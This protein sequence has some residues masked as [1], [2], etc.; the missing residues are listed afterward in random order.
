MVDKSWCHVVWW[1]ICF[2]HKE[3]NSQDIYIINAHHK[4][5]ITD[6]HR[7][8]RP[9]P[10]RIGELST[11]WSWM[12][13]I[14][15]SF[16]CWALSTSMSTPTLILQ[17][18][19]FSPSLTAKTPNPPSDSITWLYLKPPIKQSS[20]LRLDSVLFNNKGTIGIVSNVRDY[21]WMCS[22]LSQW[23]HDWGRKNG[24]RIL[25]EPDYVSVCISLQVALMCIVYI[26]IHIL[27][28]PLN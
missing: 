9:D 25:I 20:A 2:V 22:Y 13:R 19:P 26:Y 10:H 7:K 4:V 28:L 6:P 18:F 23:K 15:V 3:G 11:S 12:S 17:S 14:L 27:T 8:L 21:K 1:L 16:S 24:T 5:K